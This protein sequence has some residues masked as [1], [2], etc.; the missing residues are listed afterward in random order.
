ML[1]RWVRKC[2]LLVFSSACQGPEEERPVAILIHQAWSLVLHD[3]WL[4]NTESRR[5][6]LDL[7]KSLT[8]NSQEPCPLELFAE[9]ILL[10]RTY[11]TGQGILWNYVYIFWVIQVLCKVLQMS[12]LF[13]VIQV[14]RCLPWGGSRFGAS[15]AV[16]GPHRNI[17]LTLG[18][19]WSLEANHNA[20]IRYIQMNDY[21]WRC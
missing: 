13:Q 8:L 9:G 11:V 5:E 19:C 17:K 12:S 18:W 2:L 15:V 6:V 1:S 16:M 4:A 14:G 20:I 10:H 7:E 21:G 3:L